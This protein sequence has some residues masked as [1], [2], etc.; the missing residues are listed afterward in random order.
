MPPRRKGKTAWAARTLRRQSVPPVP[1]KSLF[2]GLLRLARGLALL[3]AEFREVGRE[4][5][6]LPRSLD[7]LALLGGPRLL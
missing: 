6:R 2:L 5:G 1:G 7:A 3:A 4:V